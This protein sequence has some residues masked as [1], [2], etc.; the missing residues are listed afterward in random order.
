MKKRKSGR[1]RKRVGPAK[2]G[3]KRLLS[4]DQER[5]ILAIGLL[6]LALFVLLA[7]TPTT[8]LGVR[9]D[10]WFPSGNFMGPVGGGLGALLIYYLGT[11]SIFIPVLLTL[12]GLRSGDWLSLQWTLRLVVLSLGLLLLLPPLSSVWSWAPGLRGFWGSGWEVL[13]WR[14][15]RPSGL[16]SSLRH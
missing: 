10:A 8:F 1:N 13:S 7:L 2:Q 14:G 16:S 4:R 15:W 3:R 12:A 11:A 5:E 9:S 6:V